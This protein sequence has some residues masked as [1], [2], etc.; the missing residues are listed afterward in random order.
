M[1]HFVRYTKTSVTSH[2]PKVFFIEVVRLHSVAKTILS[3][4]EVKFMSYFWKT[5]RKNLIQLSSFLMRIILR[6]MDNR[7]DEQ[8]LIK[9]VALLS[10]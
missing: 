1:A 4:Q 10:P 3:G 5:F 6:L 9:F 2:V 8:E 7:T